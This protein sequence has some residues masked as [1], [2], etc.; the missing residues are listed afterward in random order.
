MGYV[1]D[2]KG[3]RITVMGLG[4]LG[5]SAGDAAFLA[6]QGAK[7]TVTDQKPAE[8]LAQ[9]VA[10]LKGF[11]DITFHLGGHDVQDFTNTD[12]VVKAA[13]VPLNSEYIAAARKAGVPVV[14]STALFTAYA[15]KAGATIVGV[16]GTRGKSTTSHMIHHALARAGKRSHL[17]GNVRGV[18]TLALLPEVRADDIVVLELDSWQ[19]QGFG[20]LGISPDI[21]VFT[22]LMPDHQNYYPNMDAY[23]ADKAHIFSH[24]HPGD[25]LFIG[26]EIEAR[27]RAA[28]PPSEP[29]VIGPLP[30]DWELKVEGEHNRQNA[31]FASAVLLTLG[32]TSEKIKEALEAFESV[33]GRLQYLGLVDGVKIYNDNNATTPQATIA[34]LKALE[35]GAHNI[36]LIAGGADK[37]LNLDEL[38]LEIKKTCK[39]VHLLE[40][41]GTP[42]LQALLDDSSV[43]SSIEEA[44]EAA[45]E[46]AEF[47]DIILFS[48]AFASFGM[49]QNE[50][51]RNDQFVAL[52]KKR[53]S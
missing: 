46:S 5:R 51:E 9:S 3:K 26:S 20:D 44:V 29:T 11:P 53:I 30:A 14:M 17:G 19:L 16:T 33:E 1:E 18:S 49:F 12:M 35:T 4:V 24:Q 37:N 15:R 25:S 13:G 41:T 22:N 21:S 39:D 34:A 38:A 28:N 52:V 42:R 23:F 2:F 31:A 36:V 47:G 8:K 27:V 7:V 10:Q 45:F 48:P 50:Y 6:V 43:H 40:G 32:L